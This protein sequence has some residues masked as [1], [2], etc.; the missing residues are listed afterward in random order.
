MKKKTKRILCG[1]LS[2]GLA[3]TLV[4]EQTLRLSASSGIDETPTTASAVTFK[5]VTGTMDTSALRESQL[6]E[7]VLKNTD[8]TPTY[9]T[10]TV[11]VTLSGDSLAEGSSTS[12]NAYLNTFTG[13]NHLSQI[14]KEQNAFLRALKSEGISYTEEDRY[15]T[16]LNAVAIEVNTKYVSQIKRM[17]GVE[18]VVITTSYAEPKT[19]TS[20][21]NQEVF[22][23]TSVYKTGIYESNDFT[24]VNGSEND[25]GEGTVIAILDTG[26]DYTHEAFQRQPENPAWSNEDVSEKLN[27]L[28]LRAESRSNGLETKDVY[29][30]SKVPFAYDYADDDADVY[31]SYSNHGTHVA[32][33]IGGYNENG[34]TDKD[35]N[36]ITDQEFRG[37]VP[38]SQ[39]VICKVFTDDLEDPELGG[40]QAEDIIAALEDCVMLDVDVINMSLGT[41]CGFST[42]NDGDDEGEML[43]AVYEAIAKEGIS[44]VCAASNDY[45]AG[46]GGVFG[47]NLKQNPDSSTVGSP[48]TFASALSVASISGQE[49]PYMIGLD[50]NG[51][52]GNYIF[53]EESRDENSNPFDFVNQMLG[54]GK[55]EPITAE[56]VVIPGTGAMGHYSKA[57][58]DEFK[59]NRAEGI[60]SI[61]LVK[62]GD[63]TF[64]EKVQLAK[65][66]G[67][68]AIIVYNNVAGL[69]RMNLGEIEEDMRIPAVSI[70]MDAG[71]ALID[72]LRDE[73]GNLPSL[74]VG[75][76]K[77]CRDTSAGPFMSEFSSW[78]PTHDLKLKPEIT[79]H[80]GEITS[81][82]PGG[83]GEQSGTSMASPNMAGVMSIIRNY[84]ENTAT[85]RALITE[86]GVVNNALVNR[87]ANQLIMSTATMVRDQAGRPYSPRKQGAGLGSLDKVINQTS[88]Y[89]W[90][91]DA[92]S[93]YR[94][95]LEIGDDPQKSGII[96]KDRLTFKITNFGA[97]ALGFTTNHL[98]FTETVAADKLAIA[99]QAHMLDDMAAKWYVNGDLISDGDAITVEAGQTAT[100]SVE[101]EL[102]ADELAY[103]GTDNFP[104]GMY[105][106]GF[107]QLKSTTQGQCD[108]SIPFLGFHGDWESATML[109]YTAYDVAKDEADPSLEDSEKKQASVWATQPYSI[110][111][112]EKYILPMGSY[113]YLVDEH[114]DDP[115]Y[116]D[117]KFNAISR[118][119]TY[120]GDDNAKNYLTTTGIKAV[121]AGLLRNARLVTYSLTNVETGE[122]VF[123]DK[124]INRVGKAYAGGGQAVPGNVEVELYPEE[125][126]LLANGQYRMDFTFYMNDPDKYDVFATVGTSVY[127]EGVNPNNMKE[128][129]SFTFTVDYDAPVLEDARIRYKTIK[130]SNGKEKQSIYLDLDVYD[131]H[132]AQ[133]VMLCYPKT[134]SE[135]E[136]VLQLATDYAT[137]VRS[138]TKNGTTTV[139]IEITDIYEQ[140]GN[141]LYV[142]IDDYAVNSCLYQLDLDAMHAGQL[143]ETDGFALADGEKNLTLDIYE[144]HKVSLVYEG[145]ADVSNFSWTTDSPSVAQVKDGEIVGLSAGTATISVSNRKGGVEK[146]NVTVTNTVKSIPEPSISFGVIKTAGEA[147]SK[148]EGMVEVNAGQTMELQLLTDPWYHPMT[149]LTV[150]WKSHDENVATVDDKGNVTTLKKGIVA[151]EAKLYRGN[152][153]TMN[154][155]TV[156]LDVV[157]EFDVS[158]YILYDYNGVGYSTD[159]DDGVLWIPTDMNIMYIGEDAF[160]DNDNVKAVVI[161]ASVV[162][163][164]EGAFENCS[165]LEAVYFV[166]TKH[167]ETVEG[168]VKKIDQTIDWADCSLIHAGAFKNC[169]NLKTIDLTNAKTITVAQDCFLDCIS[170]Q[171]IEKMNNIGTMYH[172]A[173]KGCESLTEI[174]LT[175]TFVMGD[176]VFE[177]CTGIDSIQT[178]RFTVI[179]KEAFKNC[180]GLR[181][182]LVLQTPNIGEGAFSG[183]EYLSGIE[184]RSPVGVTLEFDIGERAFENCG[185]KSR[186]GF[187]VDFGGEII[188]TIGKNAFAGCGI[189]QINI[190]DTFDYDAL[191]LGGMSFEDITVSLA[192][193]YDG[194][195]Y[196]MEDGAIYTQDK[197][198][199]LLVNTSLTGAFQIPASVTEIGSYAFANSNLTTITFENPANITKLGEGAFYGAKIKNIDLSG[200]AVAEIPAYAFYETYVSSI[201]LNAATKSVG[202][203]AFAYSAIHSGDFTAVE[204]LGNYVFTNCNALQKLTTAQ[205][206]DALAL[207]TS[208][209]TFGDGVFAYCTALQSAELPSLTKMGAYTFIGASR[210]T[211][212]TFADGATATGEYTFANSGIKSFVFTDGQTGVGEGMFYNCRELTEVTLPA[213][214]GKTVTVN[215]EDTVVYNTVGAHAFN[216]CVRLNR[217]T[218]LDKVAYFGNQA[219]YNTSLTTLPLVNAKEIGVGA[220]AD[221]NGEAKYTSLIMPVVEKI[222]AYAFLNGGETTV[223]LPASV[224]EIGFGAFASSK[225]LIGFT[226]A[227]GNEKFVVMD[228]DEE[229]YGV[230]YRY[231]DKAAKTYEIVCYP[232]ARQQEAVNEEKTYK[233]VDGTLYVQS[234]AFLDLNE[235]ALDGIVLPHSLNVIGDEAFFNSGIKK[236]TFESVQA[237]ILETS[238]RDE[239]AGWVESIADEQAASYYKGYYYTNFE[240]Y[241]YNFTEFK[242]ETSEL[243]MYYPV[244]GV[245]YDNYVYGKYF[246]VRKQTAIVMTDETRAFM[247]TL[248][249][250]PMED[251]LAM[252]TWDK[253]DEVKKAEAVAYGEVISQLRASYDLL[254]KDE[255]QAPF[256]QEKTAALL[257]AETAIRQAKVNF[258]LG[259]EITSVRQDRTSFKTKYVV[260]E[261]FDITGMKVTLL[262]SGRVVDTQYLTLVSDYNRNLTIEDDHVRVLYD[263]GVSSIEF[264]VAITVTAANAPDETPDTPDVPDAPD[265]P[266][267]PSPEKEN[268][269]WW[270]WVVIGGGVAL[271]A[272]AAVLTV[273]LLKKKGK[274]ALKETTEE[275]VAENAETEES[276]VE[277]AETE[278]AVVENAKTEET[279]AENAETEETVAENAKTEE[280][281]AE[282]AET[283]EAVVENAKTEE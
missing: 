237:P 207:G 239:V 268:A 41:S 115:V 166:S 80:G 185:K 118:Y 162:Q 203:Y 56:Y 236:Y 89:L 208:L 281:V 62:R 276:V 254:C 114:N 71:N 46:Y 107:L 59:A 172:R 94:P 128:E 97:S 232:A 251:I 174:D 50:K 123:V 229:G 120:Y 34:Y 21:A 70:D 112:N 146:I 73:K 272:G 195:K 77:I 1:L 197:S 86:E 135:G 188:R 141:Q 157:D 143:P 45:S 113:V 3:S 263:D 183:C 25:Y 57:I 280:T 36:E 13:Q 100:I 209:T 93:D 248:N 117:E 58:T 201:T 218:N 102:S 262:P 199:L 22:N 37:V 99:E 139:S 47:T 206:T 247:D 249:G 256:V 196:A 134:N 110:Y 49:S 245:G 10:R 96:E 109:D 7:S 216:G 275:T 176:N 154:I 91:N 101:L 16:V 42:T 149:G 27:A 215:G 277:N 145:T 241:F 283:E 170:L 2:L 192:A 222:G 228:A 75:K 26:L 122:A 124:E 104:N 79:A 234:S 261:K 258:G 121:Y 87:L 55:D 244:N 255:G 153:P 253:T 274:K 74:A 61:A 266:D 227:D 52:E 233:V 152:I 54:E 220:F 230:L 167:R 32:G 257:A 155:A 148:A 165:A 159:K 116:T 243:E 194:A 39:L 265:A 221:E 106:E 144:A 198:K 78:G 225:N 168:G 35:G 66:M 72:A 191:R 224:E 189:E 76:I 169:K 29:V 250:L 213:F 282:S 85:T 19:I 105:L 235:G 68:D 60:L 246:G 127:P 205:E 187:T 151:I 43:N 83:Y 173:F 260:G 64:Q 65:R 273:L 184:F 140:Y 242:G 252:A 98:L 186:Y 38:D 133:A 204:T 150:Q 163:I 111:Y 88:A 161:P 178:G 8:T 82:V 9:E 180:T 51:G 125:Y 4:V 160:K 81:T 212:A 67:A 156:T 226:V 48:S 15:E 217:A 131:N 30:S 132:Y 179:G 210:L 171:K 142:Q 147:L 17:S 202:D 53:F 138:K 108:L 211:T 270:L 31:P 271:L 164:Q 200:V 14:R 84:I 278:E 5:D 214:V 69:I 223:E 137:P 240:T 126:G 63:S 175:G 119:N 103:L 18:S 130:D 136:L 24:D 219:F 182:K 158:N 279:V 95:K 90:V 40:A 11:M 269:P 181:D 28:N 129:Y 193:G 264:R 92:D 23:A 20:K 177:G 231:I 238:Y 12:V 190:D 267:A 259:E 33:I 6:N 44:L